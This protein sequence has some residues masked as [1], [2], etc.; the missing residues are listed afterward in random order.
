MPKIVFNPVQKQK[1]QLYPSDTEFVKTET[2]PLSVHLT[3]GTMTGG[4]TIQPST[5]SLTALVVNDKD[6]NNVLTV[7]T[8]NNRVGIGTAAPTAKLE[9]NGNVDIGDGWNGYKLA[10]NGAVDGTTVFAVQ[11]GSEN[12]LW[13]TRANY[14]DIQTNTVGKGVALTTNGGSLLIDTTGSVS[15]GASNATL[16]FSSTT[17][18]KQITTGGTTNLALMPG[19]NVGIG[20]TAPTA[21]LHIVGSTNTQQLIVKGNATQTANLQEWQL[22][23]ASI[24]ANI[25]PN[26]RLV[27]TISETG[28]VGVQGNNNTWTFTPTDTATGGYASITFAYKAGTKD[29][30]AVSSIGA[31]M[32]HAGSGTITLGRGLHFVGGMSG[33]GIITTMNLIDLQMFGAGAGT[34]PT[35]NAINIQDLSIS[36]TPTTM[37]GIN[38]AAQ[39]AVVGTS[40]YGVYINHIS[41]AITNNYAL[42]TNNGLVRFGD[43][44]SVNKT[45]T[46]GVNASAG[47]YVP[48]TFSLTADSNVNSYGGYFLTNTSSSAFNQA[49]GTAGLQ[50]STQGQATGGTTASMSGITGF[51]SV[52]AASTAAYTNIYGLNFVAHHYGTGTVASAYGS[53]ST[54]NLRINGGAVDGNITSAYAVYGSINNFS[55]AATPGVI[56]NARMVSAA[57]PGSTGAITNCYGLYAYNQG[58]SGVTNAYGFYVAA[59]SGAATLNYSIYT[60]AGLIHFGDTVDLASGKNLTLLAGNITTDTT[61][62][63]KIGTATNQ[64]LALFNATPVVQPAHI[65][66]PT[67]GLVTD[68]EARTAIASINAVLATLGLTAA[69]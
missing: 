34:I 56:A 50:V 43:A 49:G 25:A 23:D 17:G 26:G 44:V 37:R 46:D 32:Y 7:D 57:S 64:K 15:I 2:D 53:L 9:I 40:K 66:D 4:L 42:Y 1:L 6:A 51:A 47:L 24:V 58:R 61:T 39:T 65:D 29:V 5:D 67:G 8:I 10:L 38:K 59:Q 68:A 27:Q 22:S 62:G 63:T 54:V 14:F 45:F 28:T 55:N 16:G 60:N 52:Q 3:G 33:T 31:S 19:G 69:S 18:V 48:T 11:G 20:I 12:M 13:T 35:V 41:G 21:K 30:S 36:G